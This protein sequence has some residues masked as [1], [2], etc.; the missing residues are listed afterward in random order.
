MTVSP[1]TAAGALMA[2]AR[3]EQAVLRAHLAE[4][5]AGL[6]ALVSTLR[7]DFGATR[8][9]LFGSLAWGGFHHSSDVDVAVDGVE[10]DD[11]WQALGALGPLCGH[12]VDLLRLGKMP[13]SFRRRVLSEGE[14][15]L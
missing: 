9:V 1:E 12:R 10:G 11:Y 3:A 6:A 14:R 13:A 4:V 2:R 5:R 7:D 8:V 15:L